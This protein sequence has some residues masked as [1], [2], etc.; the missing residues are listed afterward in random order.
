MIPFRVWIRSTQHDSILPGHVGE[1]RYL[2]K[3]NRHVWRR[4]SVEFLA[5]AEGKLHSRLKG[6][7]LFPNHTSLYVAASG[8][9]VPR[10][11]AFG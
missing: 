11:D 5:E 3:S 4:R 7:V 10:S 6:R 9:S 1:R 8:K 2:E